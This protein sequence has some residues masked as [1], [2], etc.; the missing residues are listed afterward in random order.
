[1]PRVL[2]TA[3][4][5]ETGPHFELLRSAGF[6][7]DVVDRSLNLW[8]EQSLVKAADGYDAILAG[9]EPFTEAVL[10][11]LPSLRVLSR[12]GVGWDAIDAKVCDRLGIVIA[13]TPGVNH[14]SVAEHTIALLMG[15]SRGFPQSDHEVRQNVWQRVARPRVMSRTLG[16]VGLGRIGQAVAWRAIGLGMKVLACDQAPSADFVASHNVELVSFDDLLARSDYVSLHVPVTPETRHLIDAS[17]IEKMRDGVV[18]INTARG[19]LIDETALI[20]AL[21]SGKVAAAGLDVFEEEPLPAESPLLKRQNV[22]LSGHVAGLDQ[23]SHRDTCKMAAE[24]IIS[25][26]R[27]DWPGDRIQNLHDRDGWQW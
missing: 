27:G 4:S 1:M 13:I 15:V 12:T 17:A 8:D 14:D 11:Q 18:I 6:D 25:L 7:C 16:L 21:E 23:E 24:T 5:T 2:C 10:T 22:L 3:L 9:S 19:P 26:H 20:S